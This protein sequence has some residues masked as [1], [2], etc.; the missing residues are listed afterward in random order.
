MATTIPQWEWDTNLSQ[1]IRDL[2]DQFV[3]LLKAIAKTIDTRGHQ[4]PNHSLR[5]CRLALITGAE[6]GIAA[7]RLKRLELAALLHDIGKLGVELP[8]L[9]K[10]EPLDDREREEI[11]FHPLLGVRILEPVRQLIDVLPVIRHH[12]EWYDGRGYPDGLRGKE[13]PLE[14]RVLAVAD[15]F[16]AMTADRPYRKA[17]APQ[18]AIEELHRMSGTQFDPQVVTAFCTAFKRGEVDLSSLEAG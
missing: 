15:A 18:A 4:T 6:L 11:K 17:R 12:H 2:Q 14:P 1:I 3:D 16:E 13:I 8:I 10:P 5:V 9:T 7:R